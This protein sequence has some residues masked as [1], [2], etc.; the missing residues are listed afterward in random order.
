MADF[1]CDTWEAVHERVP[2]KEGALTVT[3]ICHAPQP[4][5]SFALHRLDPGDDPREVRL[6]LEAERPQAAPDQRTDVHVEFVTFIDADVDRV[7]IEV[8]AESIPV[9]VIA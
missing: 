5:W 1:R 9:E 3:G 2:G 4:G 6:R 7:T 8:V